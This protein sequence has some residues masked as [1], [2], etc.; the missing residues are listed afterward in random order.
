[1]HHCAKCSFTLPNDSCNFVY[2]IVGSSDILWL[3]PSGR[4][5]Q[6]GMI[7]VAQSYFLV[8]ERRASVWNFPPN[9]CAHSAQRC[10]HFRPPDRGEFKHIVVDTLEA[11]GAVRNNFRRSKL[12]PSERAASER[13]EPCSK[14]KK[15]RYVLLCIHSSQTLV[16]YSFSPPKLYSSGR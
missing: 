2:P 16:G 15:L 10:V 12:F 8:S 9:T 7:L 3:T 13:M 14:H 4:M 1:M 11:Y 5:V 6:S